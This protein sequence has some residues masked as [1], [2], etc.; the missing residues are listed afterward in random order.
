MIKA[1]ER[2]FMVTDQDYLAST[3]ESVFIIYIGC[4]GNGRFS[5][6]MISPP[7]YLLV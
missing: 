1:K 6:I 2:S 7:T 4:Q 3:V 5:N